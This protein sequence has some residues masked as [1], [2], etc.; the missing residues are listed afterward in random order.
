MSAA[1]YLCDDRR[2]LICVPYSIDGL[3]AMARDLGI[4]RHWFHGGPW[5][6]YDIPKRRISEITA[7]C[8]TVSPREIVRVIRSASKPS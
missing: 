4:P 3:H 2:H 8:E 5:A 1:R 6:H 7:R